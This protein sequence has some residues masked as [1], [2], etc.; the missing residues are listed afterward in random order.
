MYVSDGINFLQLLLSVVPEGDKK[1]WHAGNI[2][3][4]S[5]YITTDSRFAPSRWETALL[6]NDVSHWLGASLESTTWA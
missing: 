3:S 2:S 6:C 5:I 1:D 4:I